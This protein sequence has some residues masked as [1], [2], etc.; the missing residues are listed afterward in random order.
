MNVKDK[1]N[2]SGLRQW[3][4]AEKLRIS[5]FTLSR[6][7]RRPEQLDE[8]KIN[9]IEIAINELNENLRRRCS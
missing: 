5:E 9:E 6:W 8:Q 4:V 3:E 2:K 1:I 7:L